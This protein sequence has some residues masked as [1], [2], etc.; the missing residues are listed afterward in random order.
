[1]K[2]RN[3]ILSALCMLFTL[4]SAVDC[5]DWV[6]EDINAPTGIELAQYDNS[7][8]TPLL[9]EDGQCPKEA[10]LLRIAPVWEYHCDINIL[11]PPITDFRIITLTD[12]DENHPAGS[13]V[14]TL[15]KEY[16]AEILK[17]AFDDDPLQR[18]EPITRLAS[19]GAFYK[20]LL[21]YPQPGTYQ[22]RVELETADGTVFSEET[23]PINLY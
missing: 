14:Y 6:S 8:D 17:D 16:P 23:T 19:W 5:E 21:T 12:F 2:T 7:G 3:L 20:A 11:E 10:Y 1:M 15:F 13:D 9:R 4:T 18:G 22:F